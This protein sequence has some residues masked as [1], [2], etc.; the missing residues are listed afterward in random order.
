MQFAEYLLRF[1]CLALSAQEDLKA[2]L[3]PLKACMQYG[4]TTRWHSYALSSH[5]ITPRV[6][7]CGGHQTS[8]ASIGDTVSTD[9]Q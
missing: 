6:I 1:F 2:N 4:L 9:V 5:Q 8:T 3:G 7:N